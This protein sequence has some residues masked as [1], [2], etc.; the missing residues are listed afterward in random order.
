M[1]SYQPPIETVAIFNSQSFPTS[2]YSGQHD[3]TKLNYP[4]AQ[5]IPT[6]PTIVVS[7]N[8]SSSTISSTGIS[9]SGG[10]INYSQI[11]QLNTA[12]T[13]TQP[14][15]FG[16]TGNNIGSS[17]IGTLGYSN[18][19]IG[20]S[21]NFQ[22]NVSL[23]NSVINFIGKNYLGYSLGITPTAITGSVSGTGTT[24]M[25]LGTSNAGIGVGS[26]ILGT[27]VTAGTYVT[28]VVTA[29]LV[30]T[31]NQNLAGTPSIYVPNTILNFSLAQIYYITPSATAYT[32][33]LPAFTSSNSG[34]MAIFRVVGTGAG[35]VSLV[36]NSG[37]CIFDGTVST[38][39]STHTIYAGASSATILSHTFMLLPTTLTGNV[40]GYGWFQLGSV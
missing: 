40:N 34:A 16:N 29:G 8:G 31:L 15:T 32:I 5:G 26:T 27:G 17:T 20:N 30:F 10:T 9:T 23:S 7:N 12:N 24:T 25:T 13:Y 19:F 36:P 11:P 39:V 35:A 14:Q 3:P 22:H 2:S 28:A 37:S 21:S 1:S 6:V 38:G 33:T 18:T 4:V